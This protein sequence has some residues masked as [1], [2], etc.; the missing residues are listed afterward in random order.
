M[1]TNL[2]HILKFY[3][4]LFIFSVFSNSFS[5]TLINLEKWDEKALGTHSDS[6]SIL[7]NQYVDSYLPKLIQEANRK[8]ST[9][10]DSINALSYIINFSR[11]Y[12][13]YQNKY[14]KN[15]GTRVSEGNNEER[16]SLLKS[17]QKD[18]EDATRLFPRY[19]RLT[20]YLMRIVNLIEQFYWQN[21]QWKNYLQY[22]TNGLCLANP[23]N[24][25][26]LYYRIGA[27]YSQLNESKFACAAYDSAIYYIFSFHEDSL[28]Q[29]NNR[30]ENILYRAL[31]AR[32]NCEEKLFLD[33]A[34]LRSWNHALLIAAD[35]LKK[36]IEARIK[37]NQWDEGNLPAFEKYYTAQVQ[38]S[39]NN[40]KA[41]RMLLL[42]VIPELKTQPARNDVERTLSLIEYRLGYRF[43][44][45]ERIWKIITLYQPSSTV[46]AENDSVFTS[47]LQTYAQLCFLQGN[48]ELFTLKRHQPAFIYLSKAAEINNVNQ[49]QALFLLT[50]L[51]TGDKRDI[52]HVQKASEY[53][54]RAWNFEE[55]ELSLTYKQLLAQRLEW[56]YAQQ[57]DFDEALHWRKAFLA[58]KN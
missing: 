57:G 34:A 45:L 25:Y 21:Q 6:I 23:E 46:T 16:L 58:L 55:Q 11:T 2:T 5:Q 39:Q 7:N 19:P 38:S 52:I 44:A 14:L 9:D 35:T 3:R 31:F 54:H 56:I 51:L 42:E 41:A 50:Y 4:F 12:T 37:R 8:N 53:G 36:G 47:Y 17:M 27:A 15:N 33:E 49:R 13:Q 28:R 1:S 24:K 40:L 29:K 22:A 10:E 26:S 32:A 30:F 18:L 43:Q 20:D 48:Y